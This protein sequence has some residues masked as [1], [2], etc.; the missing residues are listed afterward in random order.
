MSS[1]TTQP[2]YFGKADIA[3]PSS[4]TKTT[5]P[6][7]HSINLL[8]SADDSDARDNCRQVMIFSGKLYIIKLHSDL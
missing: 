6:A 3:P 2:D 1:I 5:A 7:L 8:P 4:G